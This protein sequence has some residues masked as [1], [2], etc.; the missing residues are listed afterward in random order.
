MESKNSALLFVC[1]SFVCAQR[2]RRR[3]NNNGVEYLF[4]V[5]LYEYA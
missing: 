3:D 2:R 4:V 5:K 1:F